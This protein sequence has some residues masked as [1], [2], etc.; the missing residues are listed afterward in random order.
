MKQTD[1]EALRYLSEMLFANNK[2]GDDFK[3]AVKTDESDDSYL[4]IWNSHDQSTDKLSTSKQFADCFTVRFMLSPV[5]CYHG[6]EYRNP[7][8]LPTEPWICP[9]C[10]RKV[11]DVQLFIDA[12]PDRGCRV[13]QS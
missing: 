1:A 9:H 11:Y 6:G 12:G 3:T 7:K 8:A 13:G 4:E 2:T 10:E 5:F